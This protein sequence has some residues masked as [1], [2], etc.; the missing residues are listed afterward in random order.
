[1][2]IFY[3]LKVLKSYRVCSHHCGI[4]LEINI[5][6]YF[7]IRHMFSS[8]VSPL[9]RE[10][11]SRFNVSMLSVFWWLWPAD[12]AAVST[13]ALLINLN[14]WPEG[15]VIPC[16]LGQWFL[17]LSHRLLWESDESHKTCSQKNAYSI[18]SLT[19]NFLILS[20]GIFALGH[21]NQTKAQWWYTIMYITT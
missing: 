10:S 12:M 3:G 6:R 18:H 13:C 17:N 1:M 16:P 9:P 5:K 11:I 8:A 21:D 19:C 4:M 7:K 20:V 15:V 14:L 2:Q